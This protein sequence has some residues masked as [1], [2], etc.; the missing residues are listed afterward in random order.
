MIY[1]HELADKYMDKLEVDPIQFH[2]LFL[3]YHISD[4]LATSAQL[5]RFKHVVLENEPP[6][7]MRKRIDK[8]EELGLIENIGYVDTPEGST[9]KYEVDSLIPTQKFIDCI[10]LETAGEE[11]WR[12]YPAAFPLSNGSHFLARIGDKDDIITLYNRKIKKDVQKHQ[13]VLSM[14]KVFVDL[15]KNKKLNG[16]KIETF[17]QSEMW[18]I[19]NEIKG[20]NIT[21]SDHG[22]DI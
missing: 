8:L 11:L 15:V 5:E 2:L 17:V 20:D 6:D 1:N 4:N 10:I 18:D 14:L 9:K 22:V 3:L 13:F 12:N 16:V 19:V 21:I 7:I